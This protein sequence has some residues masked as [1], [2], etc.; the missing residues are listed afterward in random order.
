MRERYFSVVA[1]RNP[2]LTRSP[3]VK[4]QKRELEIGLSQATVG[5]NFMAQ[6]L[7]LVSLRVGTR[8]APIVTKRMDHSESHPKIRNRSRVARSVAFGMEE[9]LL[10]N[11]QG[12]VNRQVVHS[13]IAMLFMM[14]KT[15]RIQLWRFMQ[16]T[17]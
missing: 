14:L 11:R 6:G 4:I 5:F 8:I 2:N 13:F 16:C 1:A 12:Q 17:K 7:R 9:S 3:V 10:V 15:R